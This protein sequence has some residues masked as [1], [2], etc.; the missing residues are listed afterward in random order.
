MSGDNKARRPAGRLGYNGKHG[1]YHPNAL[2]RT[3]IASFYVLFSIAYKQESSGGGADVL[4][5]SYTNLHFWKGN[6]SSRAKTFPTAVVAKQ[7]CVFQPCLYAMFTRETLASRFLNLTRLVHSVG[8]AR[9]Y[10]A[11]SFTFA[12]ADA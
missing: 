9:L 8:Y 10:I 2:H 5:K 6:F 4:A 11:E 1:W 12:Y 3:I 7:L